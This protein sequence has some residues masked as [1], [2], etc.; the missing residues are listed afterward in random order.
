MVDP[1][2]V[3]AIR[4]DLALHDLLEASRRLADPE[5]AL[6]AYLDLV[7]SVLLHGQSPGRPLSWVLLACARRT[8]SEILAGC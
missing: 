3:E 7:V 1:D 2:D 8:T 4:L 6:W 5:Q